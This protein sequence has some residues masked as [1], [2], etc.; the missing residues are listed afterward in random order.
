MIEIY[1]RFAMI[2]TNLH[3]VTNCQSLNSIA[4]FISYCI[5]DSNMAIESCDGLMTAIFDY[6]MMTIG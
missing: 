2:E 3:S 5:F 1:R 6:A 4:F